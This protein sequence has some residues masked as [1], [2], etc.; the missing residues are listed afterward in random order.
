[1]SSA[2]SIEDAT[3]S[4]DWLEGGL[5]VIKENLSIFPANEYSKVASLMKKYLVRNQ[6]TP[7][8]LFNCL[9]NKSSKQFQK[10]ANAEDSFGQFFLAYCYDNGIGAS[11]D[12]EQAFELYSKAAEAGHLDAQY[13]LALFYANGEGTTK[14]LEKTFKLYSKAADAGHL[15]AQ[16]NLGICYDNGEGTIAYNRNRLET[17]KDKEKVGNPSPQTSI[18][19]YYR[20][21]WEIVRNL[22]ET[23]QFYLKTEEAVIKM[24]GEPQKN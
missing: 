17:T 16:Y 4:L 21:G 6:K 10:A 13:N 18:G 20:N 14:N 5:I 23:F 7:E 1:M 24:N 22:E 19:T 3:S 12:S 15:N 11:Q 2:S 8:D 9:N